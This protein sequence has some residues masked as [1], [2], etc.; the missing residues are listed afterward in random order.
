MAKGA[1]A[2]ENLMKRLAAAI[3]SDYIGYDAD[4][5]KWYVWSVE[6]GERMPVALALTVPK[7]LPADMGA[8]I[9]SSDG[10]VDFE[11]LTAAAAPKVA[12]SESEQ[13]TLDRLMKEL[14]L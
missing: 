10:S 5:K 6:N 7:S 12:I 8:G 3:G 2:K 1:I 9:P 4:S 13:Q 11:A 14:D